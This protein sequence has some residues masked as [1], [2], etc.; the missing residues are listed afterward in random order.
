M[1]R[2]HVRIALWAL[3]APGV[4]ALSL[5]IAACGSS[6]SRSVSTGPIAAKPSSA[7]KSRRTAVGTRAAGVRSAGGTKGKAG[8]AHTKHASASKKPPPAAKTTTTSTSGA[9]GSGSGSSSGSSGASSASSGKS[10]SKTKSTASGGS[11]AKGKSAGKS[12]GSS[13][14]KGKRAGGSTTTP[15]TTPTTP[16]T[17]AGPTIPPLPNPVVTGT[18]GAMIATLHGENSN[19]TI[20]QNWTYSVEA[21]TAGGHPLT[22]TVLTEF[23]YNGQVVGKETP[24]THPL[25][26]GRLDDFVQFPG[27]SLAIR[28]YLQVV[29]TTPDGTVTLVWPVKSKP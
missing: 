10:T 1:S 11:S 12:G 23:T 15:T 28:I 17:P 21:T 7:G 19:P 20:N 9:T 13:S 18:S 3:S 16:T 29:V 24:P 4:A 6:S 14:G 2:R 27:A 26:N 8:T 22:G 25:T 5:A